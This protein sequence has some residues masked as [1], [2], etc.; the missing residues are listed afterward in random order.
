MKVLL[1][2]PPIEDFYDTDIRLQPLGISYLKA[3]LN[4][5]HPDVEVVIRDY[6][7]N[8]GRQTTK[9]PKELQYLREYYAH[10]DSSP[11]EVTVQ[12][13]SSLAALPGDQGSTEKR[14]STAT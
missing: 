4:R 6:H 3:I 8:H 1:I 12:K 11:L 9:I 14:F 7:H 5:D 13:G 10:P 2:Q